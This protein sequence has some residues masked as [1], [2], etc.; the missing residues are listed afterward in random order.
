VVI[1]VFEG[2][3]SLDAFGPAEVFSRAGYDVEL[4]A[5]AAGPV[6]TSNGIRVEVERALAHV[7]GEVD[8]VLV[9]GGD[10]TR[11]A[12]A[13]DGLLRGLA[14][15]A[16]RAR[17]VVSVCSGAF[18]LAEIGLL[19]GRRAT[20]HW[21]WC[22]VLARRYPAVEVDGDSI[23]VRDGEVWTSAGVTAGIDLALALVD[24]DLGVAT[25]RDVARDL[26]VYL[27]RPGGQHQF[28]VAM[29][30]QPASRPVLRELQ[31]WI[32]E[33]LRDD[34]SVAALARRASMSERTLARAFRAELGVPPADFVEQVRIEA[35]R[36]LLE[37]SDL[38]VAAVARSCGFGT[39]ETLHRAFL[40]RVQVTP[41]AYRERFKHPFRPSIERAG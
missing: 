26:V 2:F 40:R 20:T 7:R 32:R 9:A 5:V 8:T 38:T 1:V 39:T 10:G 27:Q 37:S 34:C 18:L 21:K 3:Q 31:A 41:A 4:A 13:D 16:G 12:L 25:A 36:Q 15:L 35:A 17:R 28:S 22:D 29:A 19:D 14:R 30:T 23:F 33:H 24:D 6:R 11:A